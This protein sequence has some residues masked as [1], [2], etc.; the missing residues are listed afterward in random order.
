MSVRNWLSSLLP[1]FRKRRDR[2]QEFNRELE[3]HLEIETEE[4]LD[5][6]LS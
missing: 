5:S 1:T 2:E 3:S 4:F 6:G